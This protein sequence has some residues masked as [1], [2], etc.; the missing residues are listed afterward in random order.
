MTR[1]LALFHSGAAHAA[2][3][4]ALVRTADPAI[5]VRHLVREDLLRAAQ[6]AGLT[7]A[8]R[9]AVVAELLALA[10]GG[11]AVVLCTCSTLGPGADTAALLTE[12]P[13]LRVDRPMMAAALARGPRIVVAAALA[14][15]LGPTLDLLRAVAAERG[16]AVRPRELLIADAWPLFEAG[17]QAGYAARIAAA[18][19]P[20]LAGADA[21]VL[22]QASMA[23]AAELLADAPVPVLASPQLGVA[24]AVAAWRAAEAAVA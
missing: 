15:T 7:P 6:P 14:S 22:A 5:P 4:E 13:V 20:A 9:R 2:R 17:D 19:A 1:P 11:V 3:F 8:I 16:S 23:G 10:D 18:L 24:A 12:V 21:V